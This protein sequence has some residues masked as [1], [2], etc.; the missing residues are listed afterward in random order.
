MCCPKC[1]AQYN[2]PLERAFHVKYSCAHFRKIP[3]IWALF[4]KKLINHTYIYKWNQ[5][6]YFIN[7][8]FNYLLPIISK[9]L[10]IL[11]K[12]LRRLNILFYFFKKIHFPSIKS[13][14]V[15]KAQWEYGDWHRSLNVSWLKTYFLNLKVKAK[16][17]K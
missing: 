10:H 9:A 11:N 15:R 17:K 2:N 4:L 12:H 3:T 16:C 5:H 8:S 1:R 13:Y 7:I 6:A 14:G